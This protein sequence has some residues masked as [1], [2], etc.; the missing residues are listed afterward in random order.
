MCLMN[1]GIWLRRFPSKV[2][3]DHWFFLL[4]KVKYEIREKLKGGELNK[5][6]PECDVLR[7]LKLFRWPRMLK[8]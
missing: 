8:K 6:K 3:R 4:F 5:K 1:W 7:A 2:F